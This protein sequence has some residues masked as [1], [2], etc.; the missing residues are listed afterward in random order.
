[1][2]E[3]GGTEKTSSVW[4]SRILSALL[5]IAVT[6]VGALIIQKL[7]AHDP[8]LS[9]SRTAAVPF[10]GQDRV[11]GIYQILLRDDGKKEAEDITCYI[12]IAGAKLEQYR[13]ITVPSLVP[14]STVISDSLTVKLP[15]LNPGESA[16]ISMLATNPSWLPSIPEV[17]IRGKG[18]TGEE[19]VA[20]TV[21]GSPEGIASLALVAATAL[22]STFSIY[23]VLIKNLRSSGGQNKELAGICKI[24]G[25]D[26]RAAAYSSMKRTTFYAEADRLGDEA[27]QSRD[28]NTKMEAKK[29]LIAL[30]GV[31]HVKDESKAIILYNLARIASQEGSEREAQLYTVKAK[32]LSPE[33]VEGRLRI[34]PILGAK[35]PLV[36]NNG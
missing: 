6:V 24:H 9:Y 35:S 36:D 26:A 18:I 12:R 22:L 13:V 3:V 23:R 11:V 14:T 33:E 19:Q 4:L 8:H 28:P 10:S 32:S 25:M 21:Q 1:L 7:E 31:S 29:I 17:S 2:P 30:S 34:D 16:Q 20:G 15:S 27:I 5:G